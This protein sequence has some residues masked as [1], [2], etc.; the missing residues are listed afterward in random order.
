MEARRLGERDPALVVQT[1]AAT[2]ARSLITHFAGEFNVRKRMANARSR[3]CR[4]RIA[5]ATTQLF[6]CAVAD[7][8][9]FARTAVGA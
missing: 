1:R 9:A 6:R 3:C 7:V 8:L 5:R 4:D 2:F